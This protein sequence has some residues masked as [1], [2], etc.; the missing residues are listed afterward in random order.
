LAKV[1]EVLHCISTV[2]VDGFSSTSWSFIELKCASVKILE[3][4]ELLFLW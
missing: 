2:V 1:F 4:Q 3:A